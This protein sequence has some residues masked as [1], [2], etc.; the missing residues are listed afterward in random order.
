MPPCQLLC[1]V[2]VT[3]IDPPLIPDGKARCV[4]EDEDVTKGD[5]GTGDVEGDGLVRGG[6]RW[7]DCDVRWWGGRWGGRRR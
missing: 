5:G 4:H 3:T 2:V 6:E 7:D 1:R